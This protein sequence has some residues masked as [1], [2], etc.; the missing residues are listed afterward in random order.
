MPDREPNS[1]RYWRMNS[2]IGLRMVLADA[3]P[4]SYAADP[5]ALTTHR[6]HERQL[7]ELQRRENAVQ[8][9][10]RRIGTPTP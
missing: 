4:D 10:A 9:R 3:S 7:A 1:R 2:I 6:A 5:E 8:A